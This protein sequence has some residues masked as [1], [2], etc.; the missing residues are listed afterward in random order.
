MDHNPELIARLAVGRS[1]LRRAVR[2]KASFP[3][4]LEVVPTGE[5]TMLSDRWYSKLDCLFPDPEILLQYNQLVAELD[6]RAAM[7]PQSV[8]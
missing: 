5:L 8:P 2:P 6:V 1:I 4:D 3:A 7:C